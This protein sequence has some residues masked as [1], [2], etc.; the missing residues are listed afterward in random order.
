MNRINE[1]EAAADF[2]AKLSAGFYPYDRS[3]NTE[4]IYHKEKEQRDTDAVKAFVT[5]ELF[6]YLRTQ[7]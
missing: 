7:P 6:Q 1:T 5:S 3:I 4:V 2:I